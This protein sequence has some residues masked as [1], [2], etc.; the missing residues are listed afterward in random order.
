MSGGIG[1]RVY[2]VRRA[3]G[4]SPRK[5]MAQDAFAALLTERGTRTYYGPEISNIEQGKKPLTLEDV[6]TIASVDPLQRG[7]L[8]L[9]W[10]ETQEAT[11]TDKPITSF[12]IPDSM[13]ETFSQARRAEAEPTPA[14][15][16]PEPEQSKTAAAGG[17]PAAK[18]PK[19]RR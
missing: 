4:P 9:G 14:T 19:D 12:H 10:G 5:A 3:L 16:A 2:E 8:W 11:A 17:R 18:P 7:K 6:A 15:D 13:A 1:T